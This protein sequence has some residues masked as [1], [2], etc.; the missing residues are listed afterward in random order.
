MAKA[1]LPSTTS[2][3]N[4]MMA[5]A[6]L[7]LSVE[8]GT[9][10]EPVV[11][12]ESLENH[13]KHLAQIAHRRRREE[14]ISAP[15][16]SFQ[17]IQSKSKWSTEDYL[18]AHREVVKSGLYNFQGCKISIPTNI[19]YDLIRNAL[20]DQATPKDQKVLDLLK[21][22]MPIDCKPGFGVSKPQ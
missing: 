2:A 17:L 6:L 4:G 3:G 16:T 21:Y 19:R 20:G 13:T 12:V 1:D 22:G 9:V 7:V 15:S 18:A 5:T 8:S 14:V 11:E 10:V